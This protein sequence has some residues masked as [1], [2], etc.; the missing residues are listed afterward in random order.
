MPYLNLGLD[1]ATQLITAAGLDPVVYDPSTLTID[2]IPAT[3][4]ATIRVQ[5]T[6]SVD[7]A[8]LRELIG[9]TA[10]PADVAKPD[11]GGIVRPVRLL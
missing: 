10:L 8:I 3:G 6:G 11:L 1:F 2:E 7:V 5:F 4:S 9:Y